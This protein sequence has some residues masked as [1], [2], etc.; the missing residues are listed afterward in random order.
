MKD[1][2]LVDLV[3]GEVFA[4]AATDVSSEGAWTTYAGLPVHDYPWLLADRSAIRM[5]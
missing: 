5:D 1:P 2:V 4:V 3:T